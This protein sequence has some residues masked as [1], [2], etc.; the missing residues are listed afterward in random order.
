MYGSSGGYQ[1]IKIT[2]SYGSNGAMSL[3]DQERIDS[4]PEIKHYTYLEFLKK[5]N[6]TKTTKNQT[7]KQ[8]CYIKANSGEEYNKI[9]EIC[10][11]HNVLWS[12]GTK[13]TLAYYNSK[14][15]NIIRIYLSCTGK[16]G[17][18]M[19]EISSY[20][21]NSNRTLFT[22]TEFN[23]KYGKKNKSNGGAMSNTTTKYRFKTEL[24]FY[25]EFGDDWR[26]ELASK[27][28]SFMDKYFGKNLSAEHNS[29]IRTDKGYRDK[30]NRFIDIEMLCS[31]DKVKPH[32]RICNASEI[33]DR[34]CSGRLDQY[35]VDAIE[36]DLLKGTMLSDEKA[37]E[38]LEDGFAYIEDATVNKDAIIEVSQ[39]NIIKSMPKT[40]IIGK[41]EQL[42]SPCNDEPVKLND[43]LYSTETL[44]LNQNF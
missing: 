18:C 33:R 6:T 15:S 40:S 31:V 35:D 36:D 2:D 12:S 26:E 14:T 37:I 43:S 41:I 42:I 21:S 22:F 44:K 10:F 23:K 16:Y 20:Q 11:K 34:L 9:Q 28:L 24:E 27:W 1:Y 25:L 17:M 38:I 4:R 7:I 32:Y 3:Y 5:Y 29:L 13:T 8:E 39:Q 30:D 19:S